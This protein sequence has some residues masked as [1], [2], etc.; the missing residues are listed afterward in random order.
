MSNSHARY[1]DFLGRPCTELGS[2]FIR[3]R[4]AGKLDTSGTWNTTGSIKENFGDARVGDDF[5]IRTSKNIIGEICRLGSYTSTLAVD[6]S[7]CES[8][9]QH[10]V[11]L[12]VM[13]E[14][15]DLRHIKD[16]C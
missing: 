12:I 9:V 5:Q 1:N 15:T 11:I 3:T 2:D 7:H 4:F 16:R 13:N 10:S 8:V 6:V 14:R